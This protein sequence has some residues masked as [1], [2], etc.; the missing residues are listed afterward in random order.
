MGCSCHITH[1]TASKVIKSFGK[2]AKNFD[3]EQFLVDVYFHFDYSSK[4]K[5]LLTVFVNFAIGSNVKLSNS[6]ASAGLVFQHA[7]KAF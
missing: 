5:N 1:N 2:A 6:T 4:R 3:V 7:L